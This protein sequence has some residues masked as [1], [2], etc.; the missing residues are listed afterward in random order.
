MSWCP[1][2][3]LIV[4]IPN[5]QSATHYVWLYRLSGQRVW[6]TNCKRPAKIAPL[7]SL[8][9]PDGKIFAIIY[10]DG[11]YQIFNTANGKI[12]STSS[13]NRKITS[14]SWAIQ[15]MEPLHNEILPSDLVDIDYT[16]FLPRLPVVVT[17]ASSRNLEIDNETGKI[18]AYFLEGGED[19]KLNFTLYGSFNCGCSLGFDGFEIFDINC[20][21]DLSMQYLLLKKDD[22]T[23]LG[24][25][26]AR[27]IKRIGPKYLNE[28][29]VTPSAILNLIDYLKESCKLL[30]IEMDIL[31]STYKQFLLQKFPDHAPSVPIG[32][33]YFDIALTGMLQPEIRYWLTEQTENG[34]RKIL[35]TGLTAFDNLIK[36]VFENITQAYERML[37][38]FSRL[39]GLASWKDRGVVLGLDSSLIKRAID[40]TSEQFRGAH[41]LLWAI[42]K[43]RSSYQAFSAWIETLQEQAITENGNDYSRKPMYDTSA[44]STKTV[45]DFIA[46]L[47]EEHRGPPLENLIQKLDLGRLTFM[48]E[49]AFEE[50]RKALVKQ[51]ASL[52]YTLLSEKT[53]YIYSLWTQNLTA[54]YLLIYKEHDQAV[55]LCRIDGNEKAVIYLK[56]SGQILQIQFIDDKMM[57]LLLIDESSEEKNRRLLSVNYRDQQYSKITLEHQSLIEAAMQIKQENIVVVREKLFER[58][59]KADSFHINENQ[60]RRIG[61]VLDSTCQRY[62]FFEIDKLC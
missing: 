34:I 7:K 19:G 32:P 35:K 20:S 49:S 33:Y 28:M 44:I 53:H 41:E 51:T 46:N 47:S 62:Q 43:E 17:N 18:V 52:N 5:E 36:V 15:E 30:N 45:L 8:W 23:Y 50:I 25:H 3:D 11:V 48:S 60:S 1:T 26:Q 16:K 57:M 14:L 39:I 59:F 54:C 2:M 6:S 22:K 31:K 21:K 58:D 38:Y 42:K 9:R 55:I 10:D 13:S 56:C 29:S 37:I 40:I 24:E 61:C 4:F 12:I 27:F